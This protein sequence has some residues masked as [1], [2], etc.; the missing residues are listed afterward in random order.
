M[1]FRLIVSNTVTIPVSGSMPDAA[2]KPSRF[3]FTLR[4]KRLS[5]SELRTMT[6]GVDDRTA[7]Q[8]L[9]DNVQGWDNVLDDD[10]NLVPFSRD[11]LEQ[12]LEILGM[13][14]LILSA[15]VEACGAKGAAKN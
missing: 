14:G 12:M 2:G 15:Y 9:L 7:P 4:A 8:F 13:A 3:S 11:A 6:D 1:S 10:G 5:L